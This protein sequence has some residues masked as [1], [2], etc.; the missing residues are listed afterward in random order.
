[1]ILLLVQ[2]ALFLVVV[3][4]LVGALLVDR[5]GV[6]GRDYL[7]FEQRAVLSQ[8]LTVAAFVLVLVEFLIGTSPHIQQWVFY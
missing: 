6:H 8:Q 2:S 4:L 7:V 5:S 3:G 1:M